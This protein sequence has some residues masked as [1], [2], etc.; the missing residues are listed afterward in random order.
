MWVWAS[1]STNRIWLKA[2]GVII[3]I[4][5]AI[6]VVVTANHFVIDGF[7]GAIVAL[8]GLWLSK[9]Y[10]PRL[11]ELDNRFRSRWF[12]SNHDAGNDERDGDDGEH[13]DELVD[14]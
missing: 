4:L 7:L 12:G 5:M 11:V 13:A 9:K 1:N 8:I 10:T 6:S 3:P 2:I 14:A